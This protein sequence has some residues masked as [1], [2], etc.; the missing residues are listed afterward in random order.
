MNRAGGFGEAKQVVN[1]CNNID[2][3]TAQFGLHEF[4]DC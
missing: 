4:S 1:E 3:S 2:L